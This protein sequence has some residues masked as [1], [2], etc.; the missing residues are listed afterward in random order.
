MK[1]IPVDE[2]YHRRF[3]IEKIHTTLWISESISIDYFSNKVHTQ[4]PL[5]APFRNRQRMKLMK[6]AMKYTYIQMI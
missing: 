3:I 1:Q 6:R 4:K 2:Y 5:F